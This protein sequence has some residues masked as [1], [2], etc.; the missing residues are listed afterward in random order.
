M[1]QDENIPE[2]PA[3]EYARFDSEAGFQAA[4]DKLL[5]QNGREL[6]IFDPNLEALRPNAPA[7]IESL[8]AFLAA[9]RAHRIFIVLHDPDHV[10]RFCARLMN[11]LALY[12]HAIRIHQTSEGIRQLQDGF[13]VMDK[14][15]Y[16]R[17]PVARFY[18]GACGFFDE[19]EALAMHS[20]FMEIWD[21]SYPAVS[22][23][24]SG[25]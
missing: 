14:C 1:S 6:R 18:R 16:V 8:R 3:P 20:R 17:R 19:D 4:V 23:T 12:G 21:V 25:L 11:L 5:A 24:T 13:L 15:H 2:A 7:R 9:N 22:S 10:T